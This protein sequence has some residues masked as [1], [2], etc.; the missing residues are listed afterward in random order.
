MRASHNKLV[1]PGAWVVLV[2]HTKNKKVLIVRAAI[3]LYDSTQLTDA[4]AASPFAA[5]QVT[6]EG[7]REKPGEKGISLTEQLQSSQI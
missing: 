1:W 3:Q 5:T 4:P 6:D 2:K 7:G